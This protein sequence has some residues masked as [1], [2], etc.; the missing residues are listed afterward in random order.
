MDNRPTAEDTVA[1]TLSFQDAAD[2]KHNDEPKAETDAALGESIKTAPDPTPEQLE[3]LKIA[4]E[5]AEDILGDD[6]EQP[7]TEE[8]LAQLRALQGDFQE[9]IK[10]SQRPPLS[11]KEAH[12]LMRDVG[13]MIQRVG[14]RVQET[15]PEGFRSST[16]GLERL[17]E[18]FMWISAAANSF[19]KRD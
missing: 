10:N 5:A 1:P 11:E 3:A 19:Q 15:F 7:V 2:A 4:T 18:A 12:N 9:Q 17:D 6:P 16:V 13:N 14:I 8:Q